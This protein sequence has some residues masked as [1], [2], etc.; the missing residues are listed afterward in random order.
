MLRQSVYPGRWFEYFKDES[1]IR[2]DPKT[3]L[4]VLIHYFD[5][6]DKLMDLVEDGKEFFPTFIIGKR[7]MSGEATGFVDYIR[8]QGRYNFYRCLGTTLC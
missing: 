3:F 1:K 2:G 6:F 5:N 4:H 7:E 8:S